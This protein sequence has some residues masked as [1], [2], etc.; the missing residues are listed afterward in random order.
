[1]AYQADR[2]RIN[3]AKETVATAKRLVRAGDT[4]R[5]YST[6]NEALNGLA[7]ITEPAPYLS[8]ISQV[9]DELGMGFFV[10]G[11]AGR[12]IE[13][14]KRAISL[15]PTNLVARSHLQIALRKGA[16]PAAAGPAPPTE[17]SAPGRALPADFRKE[18]LERGEAYE[19]MGQ[20]E[21]AISSY[22]ELITR[23]PYNID[24]YRRLLRLKPNDVEILEKY[25]RAL[26]KVE[27]W[28]ELVE[29]LH[30]LIDIDPRDEFLEKLRKVNP[31]DMKL[32]EVEKDLAIRQIE[33]QDLALGMRTR[34]MTTEEVE[35]FLEDVE[36]GRF[37]KGRFE[38]MLR[39]GDYTQDQLFRLSDKMF[40]MK[41]FSEANRALDR[42]LQDSPGDP[43]VWLYKGS[44]L[45]K[46]GNYEFA[47][48]CFDRATK[49]EPENATAWLNKGIVLFWMERYDE[50]IRALNTTLDLDPEEAGA[51]YY[52][53][54]CRANTQDPEGALSDLRS[55]IEKDPALKRLAR[56]DAA[57]HSIRQEKE[58]TVIT[59]E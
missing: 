40:E 7:S 21:E 43:T 44:T 58:F 18:L 13:M 20:T 52:K 47:L 24:G 46:T 32:Q 50:A 53:A 11:D 17:A 51:S 10:C 29:T 19:R 31:Y 16:G 56:S 36:A 35:A 57:F 39:S 54:C 15:D 45:F 9:Y 3:W 5:A 41:M 8:E 2:N 49:I 27:L 23:A 33:L 14:F 26:E 1:M 30:T 28:D 38:E 22:T 55:A 25:S 6:L 42:I 48:Q 4:G 12:S 34:R 59:M 37:D